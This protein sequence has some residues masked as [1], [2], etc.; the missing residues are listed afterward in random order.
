MDDEKNATTTH[1]TQL[2]ASSGLWQ[3][4]LLRLKMAQG[5]EKT[6]DVSKPT[7]ALAIC[8]DRCTCT[9]LA[10]KARKISCHKPGTR[11]RRMRRPERPVESKVSLHG[12][13]WPVKLLLIRLFQQELPC[14]SEMVSSWACQY[15]HFNQASFFFFF[16]FRFQDK[17]NN[18]LSN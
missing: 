16:F 4:Q 2:I 8:I 7:L 11:R 18:K 14:I 13:L 6:E 5:E 10:R 15:Y 9:G 12:W 1:Q 3:H 17:E